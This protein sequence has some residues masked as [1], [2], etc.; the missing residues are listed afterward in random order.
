MKVGDKYVI[1]IEEVIRRNGAPQIA[2]IKG[3]NAL[4]FDE[5]GL[6][7]LESYDGERVY[8]KGYK[9]GYKDGKNVVEIP[10]IAKRDISDAYNKGLNDAWKLVKRIESTPEDGGL[11]NKQIAEVFGQ[12]WSS[13]ELYNS[14]SAEEVLDLYKRWEDKQKQDAEIKVGDEVYSDAFDDK[15]IVTHIT[16]DKV[17]CVC[18][19]CNGSTMMRV[20]L[21]GL[22]KTGRHFDAIAEVL[23]ELRG[24][25]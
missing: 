8:R 12:Y 16:A 17:S 25:E 20:G 2:R 10:E 14:F 18:I 7:K 24:E 5:F 1:E 6:K 4:V 22:H 11:T 23:A 21:H 19:I 13:F 9:N 3:F 15:G